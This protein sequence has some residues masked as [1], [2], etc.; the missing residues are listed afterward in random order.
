MRLLYPAA[1]GFLASIPVII[2]MYILKQRFEE[3]EVS[4]LYLWEQVIKD[5]DVNTPWQRLKSSLPLILQVLAAALLV[6]ALTD[7]FLLLK[8]RSYENVILVL[9]NTGSMNAA[10]EDTTRF[11]EGKKRAEKLIKSLKPGSKITLVSSGMNPKVELASSTDKNEALNKLKNIKPTNFSGDIN[12]S[13]SLVRSISKQYKAYRAV[14]FTDGQVDVKDLEGEVQVLN[15]SVL[16]ISL[17]YISHTK[18]NESIKAIVRVNNR[19][20]KTQSREIALYAEDKLFSLKD[21]ELKP[22]EVKTIYFERIPA[23][24]KYIH[25][26]ISEKDSLIEDNSIYE[27]IR[28]TKAQRILLISE[29]NIFVEKIV[30]SLNNVELYKTNSVD[31]IKDKYDLYIFDGVSPKELPKEGSVLFINP[32]KDN[33]VVQ[34]NETIEGGLG[35]VLKNP[36]TRYMDKAHFSVSKIKDMVVPYWG[37]TFLKVN[38]KAAAFTGELKGRKTAVIAYDLHNSD[39]PL[40]SEFPIFMH[41]LLGYLIDIDFQS[42]TSYYC[43]EGININNI[44][45]VGKLSIKNPEGSMENIELKYPIRP[46]ENTNNIGIYKLS[47]ENKDISY[48]NVFAV[49][50]PTDRESDIDKEAKPM[51]NI[52]SSSLLNSSGIS[53]KIFILIAALMLLS[54]EW[55]VY[56]YGY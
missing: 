47:K 42:K 7:P 48:E 32:P 24:I 6:F 20:N 23:N 53:L 35:E 16:N 41:N 12:D 11:E 54:I 14:F 27:V 37:S 25:A 3:R 10:Y 36:V 21:V 28:Q 40:I 51:N 13:V 38:G 55:M 50:F 46:Y 15:S 2:M 34:V 33:P 18:E 4:S 17:D 39:F 8:G 52:D 31:N 5:I 26:E 56:V 1:L 43:G 19:T 29:K 45:E 44:G 30:S 22:K 9:D 49:N